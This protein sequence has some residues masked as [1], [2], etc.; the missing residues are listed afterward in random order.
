MPPDPA[1]VVAGGVGPW[2]PTVPAALRDD[3]YDLID[4]IDR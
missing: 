4:L 1:T 3:N 2:L